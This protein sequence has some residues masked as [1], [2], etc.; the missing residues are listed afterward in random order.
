M[1]SVASAGTDTLKRMGARSVR[2]C[3][4]VDVILE[5]WFWP[6]VSA[7]TALLFASL[8]MTD[9]R[10]KLWND[11]LIGVYVAR[12]PGFSQIAAM[13]LAG[14]DA[15]PPLYSVMVHS[16]LPF[17]P[18]EALAVRLP[19]TIGFCAMIIA[20][21]GYAR[22]RL[23]AAYAVIAGLLAAAMTIVFG[24]EGR[25]YGLILGFAAVSLLLW[26]LADEGRRRSVTLPLLAVCIAAM[27]ALHYYTIFFP[28]CLVVAQLVRSRSEWRFDFLLA[29][30]LLAPA[31]IVVAAYYPFIVA[32]RPFMAHN[33]STASI[34]S[35]VS[36]YKF[37]L[38]WPVVLFAAAM[39]IATFISRFEGSPPRAGASV[40][41]RELTAIVLIA[42]APIG[43]VAIIRVTTHV[44][45]DRYILWSAVAIAL[46]SAIVLRLF[47]RQNPVIGVTL[48]LVLI[49]GLAGREISGARQWSRLREADAVLALLSSLPNGDEPIILADFHVFLELSYYAPAALRQRL[50]YP[51]CP[52][53]EVRYLGYDS[54]AIVMAGLKPW[55]SLN[56]VRC[57][58]ALE[59]GR[60]YIVAITPMAF[61]AWPV[62][63]KGF[64]VTP[65]E[66]DLKKAIVVF[67]VRREARSS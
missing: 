21:A 40:P 46:L 31:A 18:S 61:L 51:I 43:V 12:S 6:I 2:W 37:F 60:D 42:L 35:I 17:L 11:E 57:D 48:I 38:K 47:A 8:L 22:R 50:I 9:F 53:L 67:R 59:P 64:T 62:E 23:P 49:A 5:R 14:A 41:A 16:L 56:G 45:T 28:V 52:D 26:S 1:K 34:S 33:W 15:M 30:V 19:S 65:L 39:L 32:A 4:D 54:D 7:L 13:T 66:I 63:E 20:I 3:A 44:F 55:T 10:L 25:S 58:K 24:S 27:S 36:S 29:I